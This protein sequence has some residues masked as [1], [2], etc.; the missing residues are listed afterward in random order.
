M[1]KQ[2][3]LQWDHYSDAQLRCINALDFPVPM[4][5]TM[6][7]QRYKVRWSTVISLRD[8]GLLRTVGLSEEGYA[9]AMPF[10]V[11]TRE[12]LAVKRDWLGWLDRVAKS[13]TGVGMPA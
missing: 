4:H 11:L 10:V 5:A 1:S 13:I 12:G 2:P 3:I 6:L 7:R 8:K 9:T